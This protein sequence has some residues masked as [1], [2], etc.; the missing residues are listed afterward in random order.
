MNITLTPEHAA[1]IAKYAAL[2]G[3]TQEEFA[4]LFLADYLKSLE[5]TSSVFDS[6]LPET[7]GAMYFRDRESAERVQA[8]L[9]ERVSKKVHLNS[10]KTRIS[11]N[12]DGTF[13]VRMSVPCTWNESGWSTIA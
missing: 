12:A 11:S 2:T 3:Y 4:S 5:D 1:F 7:I 8:W 6:S 10:I 13:D 9:I